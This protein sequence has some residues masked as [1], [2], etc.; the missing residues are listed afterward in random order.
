MDA[1]FG[2]TFDPIL[3][4][5]RNLY[6]EIDNSEFLVKKLS[7]RARGRKFLTSGGK[8]YVS[9]GI[10]GHHSP[11]AVR[12][13]EA[14]KTNGGVDQIL[15]FSELNLSMQRLKTSPRFGSFGTDQNGSEFLFIAK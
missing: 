11:F 15:T 14:L 5:S 13:L 2:G 8:E 7:T 6:D 9:D 4:S 1:C 3:A 12:V 10:P